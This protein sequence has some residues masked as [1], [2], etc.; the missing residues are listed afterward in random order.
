MALPASF[1]FLA[2][3]CCSGLALLVIASIAVLISSEANKRNPVT[4][5][6]TDQMIAGENNKAAIFDRATSQ[7]HCRKLGSDNHV[8]LMPASEYPVF[9]MMVVNMNLLLCESN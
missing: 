8:S 3:G 1:A 2:S 7:N 9:S 4:I 5:M 6:R